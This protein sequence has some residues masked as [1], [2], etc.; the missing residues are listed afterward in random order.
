V[1]FLIAC[2]FRL[3]ILLGREGRRRLPGRQQQLIPI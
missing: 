1:R 2:H 3:L